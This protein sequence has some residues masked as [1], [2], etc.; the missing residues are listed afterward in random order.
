MTGKKVKEPQ[1]LA[2]KPPGKIGEA[3]YDASL[4]DAWQKMKKRA[5]KVFLT[6]VAF[7]ICLVFSTIGRLCDTLRLILSL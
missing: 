7:C 2:P 1:T 6:P 5:D 3:A 4:H